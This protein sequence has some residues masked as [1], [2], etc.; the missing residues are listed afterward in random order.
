MFDWEKEIKYA[1]DDYGDGPETQ[2]EFSLTEVLSAKRFKNKNWKDR[3]WGR[4]WFGMAPSE[5]DPDKGERD[6]A[7][8]DIAQTLNSL[9]NSATRKGEKSLKLSFA[10]SSNVTNSPS[11]DTVVLDPGVLDQVESTTKAIDIMSGAALMASVMKKTASNPCFNEAQSDKLLNPESSKAPYYLWEAIEQAIA[12][13]EVVKTWPGF[14]AFFN[15]HQNHYSKMGKEEIR[16]ELDIDSD[17]PEGEKPDI[18]PRAAVIAAAYNTLNPDDQQLMDDERMQ[19][20]MEMIEGLGLKKHARKRY[21]K[22]K[23]ITDYINHNFAK[24]E[25]DDDDDGIEPEASHEPEENEDSDDGDSGAG[26]DPSEDEPEEDISDDFGSVDD[27]DDAPTQTDGNLF[28]EAMDRVDD[29]PSELDEI[30]KPKIPELGLKAPKRFQVYQYSEHY[31]NLYKSSYDSIKNKLKSEVRSVLGSLDFLNNNTD[32][33]SHGHKSGDLDV[34]SLYKLGHEQDPSIFERQEVMQSKKIAVGLLLD[35]SGSMSGRK[36]EETNRMA[37]VL[38]EALKQIQG[39]NLS[40]YTHTAESGLATKYDYESE[41]IV[42]ERNQKSSKLSDENLWIH[43]IIHDGV[44]RS[45]MLGAIDAMSMNS[46]GYAIKYVSERFNRSTIGYDEKIMFVISDGAP[47]ASGY[48]GTQAY[49]HTGACSNFVRHML[50]IR[51]YGVGI[52]N[53]FDQDTGENLYGKGNFII[54]NDVKSSIRVMTA[55]LRNIAIKEK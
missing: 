39:I 52:C 11:S 18:T 32:T 23:A 15:A 14:S 5:E 46:D 24:A 2:A 38:V 54:L 43:D 37:I 19:L 20:V 49:E 8:R 7:K 47:H 4:N 10:N 17:A 12:R 55:F 33:Y 53:P 40:V 42:N 27:F 16:R 31:H 22:T 25:D 29:E 26:G 41:L 1:N 51:L 36:M 34:H 28:G 3:G 50:G 44:D 30:I 6:A 35:R 45:H 13:M 9:S 21:I 48:G